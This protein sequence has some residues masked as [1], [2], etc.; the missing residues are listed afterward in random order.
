[1]HYLPATSAKNRVNIRMEGNDFKV[2]QEKI[3]F[4][5]TQLTEQLIGMLKMDNLLSGYPFTGY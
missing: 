5:E 3:C 2:L 4:G 1:M